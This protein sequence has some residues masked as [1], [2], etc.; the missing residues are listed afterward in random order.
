MLDV[1]CINAFVLWLLKNPDWKKKQ[2][3]CWHLS[4][5]KLG[6]NQMVRPYIIQR[7]SNS[8]LW[9]WKLLGSIWSHRM[10]QLP[11]LQLKEEQKED[12]AICVPEQL[13]GKI[14]SSVDHVNYGYEPLL[15]GQSNSAFQ[16][17][18]N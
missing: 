16:V 12:T 15:K 1:S 3:H 9:Q 4:L 13:T 7:A 5:L 2:R 6:D 14:T 8:S 10:I 18:E 17:H 11:H